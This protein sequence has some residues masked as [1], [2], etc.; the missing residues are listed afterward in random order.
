MAAGGRIDPPV[1]APGKDR[2]AAPGRP[3][4]PRSGEAT[5]A[6]GANSVPRP[7]FSEP[8]QAG[9]GDGQRRSALILSSTPALRSSSISPSQ[10]RTVSAKLWRKGNRWRPRSWRLPKSTQRSR[11]EGE[12]GCEL[13]QLQLAFARDWEELTQVPIGSAILELM[14]G[15]CERR[16]LRGTDA[17]HLPVDSC[18]HGP[19][20]YEKCLVIQRRR[21]DCLQLHSGRSRTRRECTILSFRHVTDTAN[22][23]VS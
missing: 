10:V 7:L 5:P 8:W 4:V 12:K 21:A 23:Y 18:S 6:D 14:P 15:L 3:G 16:P 11:A 1:P 2:A 20:T 22:C 13:E 19:V 9:L 17:V